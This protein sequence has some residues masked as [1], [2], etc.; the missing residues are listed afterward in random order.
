[1]ARN[2]H[3]IGTDLENLQPSFEFQEV[4]F[5]TVCITVGPDVTGLENK[6][7]ELLGNYQESDFLHLLY[8]Y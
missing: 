7:Y 2:D 5:G 4:T 6:K 8:I 3:L 1:M